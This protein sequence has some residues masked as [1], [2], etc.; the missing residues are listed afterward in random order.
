[1]RT[2]VGPLHS[3][4]SRRAVVGGAL[5]TALSIPL[6]T[7]AAA[8]EATPIPAGDTATPAS[9]L[10]V[11]TLLTGLADP[12]YL[13]IDADGVLFTESGTG[14]DEAV[15]QTV[16][17]GTPE[18]TAPISQTGHTGS[19]SRLS[20]DGTVTR[21]VSDFRS[22]TFGATGEIVGA[23]GLALDGAGKAYVSVGAPGPFISE[24]PLTGEEG[25]LYEVDLATGEKTVVADAIA[26]EL[27]DD[28]DPMTLDSNLYGADFVDG[29]VY[30]ADSGG[31]SILAYDTASGELT[32]LAVTGGLEAPFL[33][34][35]GNPLRGGAAELDSV[36]SCVVAGPDGRLYVS[37][38][39][40]APFP[41]GF[42]PVWVYNTDGMLEQEIPGFTMV[43]DLAF[44]SDGTLYVCIM[45][46]DLIKG[47]PGQIVRVNADGTQTIVLDNL[48][49]PNSIAFDANDDLYLLAKASMIPG[50]G[51]LVRISGVT[52]T[53][54]VPRQV[55]PAES[56]PQASPVAGA[57][58][59]ITIIFE[60]TLY[61][62]STVKVPADIEF[63][64]VMDNRGFLPHDIAIDDQHIVSGIIA[65][66]ETGRMT[67]TLPA[68]EH[69]FY[70]TQIG[71]R[72][73]G[74]QG[75]F[76]AE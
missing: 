29:V 67:L 31:N 12:R 8:Q 51:E 1:M 65:G 74:M 5:G 59:P 42:A 19:L 57:S 37:F 20:A 36:P 6:L 63:T 25:V 34:E 22:Y 66:G 76:V 41:P 44:S 27:A 23:A 73:A 4:L 33:A 75:T 70:C 10:T 14:G 21:I 26:L 13:A 30:V 3:S 53:A 50:G 45:S 40:G 47:G 38:V 32:A 49:M 28:P 46:T 56:T 17:E 7:R 43:T 9:D 54:G 68:G 64:L 61:E 35:A 39:T 16:G 55:G 24:M 62:P 58:E 69:V 71:H 11:E 52:T 72:A 15:F 18:P 48:V 2:P 60:D